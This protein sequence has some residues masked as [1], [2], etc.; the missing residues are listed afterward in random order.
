MKL[1]SATAAKNGHIAGFGFRH[2]RESK[3]TVRVMVKGAG[4]VISQRLRIIDLQ[5]DVHQWMFNGLE[6]SKRSIEL[7]PSLGVLDGR[8]Q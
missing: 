4:R 2:A 8:L 7:D 3:G 5:H 1:H 6:K